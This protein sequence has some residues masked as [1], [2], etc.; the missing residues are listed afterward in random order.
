MTGTFVQ[1]E[2]FHEQTLTG[3]RPPLFHREIKIANFHF[4]THNILPPLPLPHPL[5]LDPVKKIE[6]FFR[7][8]FLKISF[9]TLDPLHL[10][11][12]IIF[13]IVFLVQ[14]PHLLPPQL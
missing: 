11:H 13:I 8:S 12:S 7:S 2:W 1:S 14:W 10:P 6:P 9:F 5:S 3:I 4:T